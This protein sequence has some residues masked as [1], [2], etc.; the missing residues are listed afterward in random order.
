VKRPSGS[1]T[2]GTAALLGAFALLA[3]FRLNGFCLLE[4]DSPEYLFGARSLA[5]LDGYREIDRPGEPIHTLRP[6]GL[7]L[8]LVPLSW[9][10]PYSVVG[11]KLIV[12]AF[13]LAAIFLTL[14]LAARDSPAWGAVAAGLAVATSPYSLLH[15]TEIVTEFP[16]IA[17]SFTALLVMT[18][19]AERP[20]RRDVAVAAVCLAA[21]PFIRTIGLAL[22]L[23]VVVWIALDRTRRSFWPAPAAALAASGVWMVRNAIVGGPSYFGAI[24]AEL[25]R[26]GPWAF[27]AKSAGAV[28]FYGAR[29]L[30]VL[31]PG[32]RPGRPLYERMAVGGT[33]DL[34]GLYGLGVAL[35]LAFVAA[36]AL[37]V[38]S[39]R[40][41]DGTLIALYV[42]AFLLVLA[43]YPPRH[44]RL[45]WPLVPLAWAFIPA[46]LS[47]LARPLRAAAL[48]LV[49]ALVLW[50]GAASLAMA[51]D[52]LA[53][54]R[55]GDLFYTERVPPIYFADW[56]A[57]GTW[58][59]EHAPPHVRVLTRH[60]DVGFTSGL[61]QE[62]VRFEELPPQAWRARLAKLHARF[63]V[64]P[65]S[66]FGKFFPFDLLASDPAYAY[67]LRWKQRDVAVVE[68]LPN[69]SGRVTAAATDASITTAACDR[70]AA[71]PRRVDL[72]TRCAELLAATGRRDAA[73]TRLRALADRG[74]AD[75]RET[76]ALGQLLL[77]AG[78]ADDAATAFRK[79]SDLPE[80]ELLE[81]VIE[82]GRVSAERRI[83]AKGL[84]AREQAQAAIERGRAFMDALR[85]KEAGAEIDDALTLAPDDPDAL[86]AAG[87]LATRLGAYDRASRLLG[88]AG[89]RGDKRA[90]AQGAALADA[91]TVEASLA[92]ATPA[93][94]VRAAAFWAGDGS[95]GRA[96]DIL[97]RADATLPGER[98]IEA[99][100]GELRHFYGLD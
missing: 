82:R 61:V 85:W 60:S 42:P 40:R 58:L 46:G 88:A 62:R 81:Q 68:V 66:V 55:G 39:R 15:A 26:L 83:A 33:P 13:A 70:A 74:D 9:I 6:P 79:A 24:A 48:T 89:A 57:A 18:R 7:P 63:L 96:L 1:A 11:A 30:D 45:T 21:L 50:Q 98:E 44:E 2:W 97:E 84:A 14:R 20:S 59:R 52:N 54:A 23:S 37:G 22:V 94:I 17:C 4:P 36:A 47:K 28:G 72:S 67:A 29:F 25:G 95:P 3:A 77:S 65:A 71:E 93:A 12:L 90:A 32:V 31:L 8:L 49:A 75:V 99:P 43:I 51:K 87:D 100:L 5:S 69:R 41:T 38:W 76:I 19:S 53:W 78:R 10:V 91:L 80:A 27:A 56:R 34:G 86:H 92:T 64:V 73:I 16:Y 35:G